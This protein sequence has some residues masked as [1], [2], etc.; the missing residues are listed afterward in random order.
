MIPEPQHQHL[1]PCPDRGDSVEQ[2]HESGGRGALATVSVQQSFRNS[3]G[4][5]ALSLP[6]IGLEKQTGPRVGLRGVS[7]WGRLRRVQ[8]PNLLL[9]VLLLEAGSAS[10]TH[11]ARLPPR[12]PL[13]PL[14]LQQRSW[15]ST[16]RFFVSL[17]GVVRTRRAGGPREAGRAAY[18]TQKGLPNVGGLGLGHR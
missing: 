6:A 8:R 18:S 16:A 1:G 12:R 9:T 11:G 7:R 10:P 14:A 13:A 17:H 15:G 2:N 4:K 3:L 5:M